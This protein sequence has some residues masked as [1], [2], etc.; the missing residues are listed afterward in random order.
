MKYNFNPYQIFSKAVRRGIRFAALHLL[1][2]V[3]MML[4]MVHPT[5]AGQDKEAAKIDPAIFKNITWR[6]IGPA[7]MG[8]RLTDI[9]AVVGNPDIIYFGTASSGLWKSTNG[10]IT[11]KQVFGDQPVHSIGDLAIALSNP[12]VIYVGTGEDN[13]RNSVSYGNGVYKST[14]AGETW[15]H[16]GLEDTRHIS[17]VIV[18][19]TNADIAYV[20]ALG[21]VW[22]RNKERGVF[23]TIDGGKS[24]KQVLFVDEETGASDIDMDPS[25]PNILYAAMWTFQRNPWTHT[26]GSEKG[27]IYK[28][29]D[30]GLTW[31]KVEKGLPKLIGRIG[32][33]VAPSNPNVVYAIMEAK[34]GTLYRSDDRGETWKKITD[35]WNIISRGFYY[36]E[37]RVDPKNENRL[38]AVSGSLQLS[39][40][41]GR[42]WGR[43]ATSVHGD[44]HTLWIDPH[45]PHLLFNGNDG[46][47]GISRDGGETWENL[48]T[49]PTGQFYQITADNQVPFYKVF[50]G[51]Q[52]NGSWGGPAR[53]RDVNGILNDDWFTIGGGDGFFVVVHPEKQHLVLCE[54]Q[55]GYI[56]R[57]DIRTGHTQSISPQ[58]APMSG[59]AAGENEYRFDWNAPIVL[60]PHDAD[61]VYLGGNVLFKSTDFGK[62]WEAISPDLSTNDPKKLE[63]AGGPIQHE[64]TVAEYHCVIISI[65]ESPVQVGVIWIGTDDGQIQLTEDGGKNWTNLTKNVKG[66]P[67]DGFIS[68]VEASKTAAGAAYMTADRHMLDD[69][70]PYVFKTTDFGKTWENISGNLPSPAYVHV[71]REDPLNPNVLYVG[72]EIGIFVSFTGGKEWHPFKLKNLPTTAVHDIYVHPK[73]NDLIIGTHGYSI[74]ILDDITFLQ[75]LSSEVMNSD[76]YLFEPQKAWRYPLWRKK[77]SLGDKQFKGANPEY[78]ALITYYLK[79]APDD[80][81]SVKVQILDSQEKLI[82]EIKGTRDLG[83]NRIVWDLRHEAAKQRSPEEARRERRFRPTGPQVIPGEYTAK[84]IVG[85]KTQSKR[86]QVTLDPALEVTEAEIKAQFDASMQLRD[87][88]SSLNIALHALDGIELQIKNLNKTIKQEGSTIPQD[89][90]DSLKEMTNNV[91]DLQKMMFREREASIYLAPRL[92]DKV[93]SLY[94]TIERGNAAPT[95]HQMD[96]LKKLQGELKEAVQKVNALISQ[97]IPKLNEVLQNNNLPIF[98]APKTIESP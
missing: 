58:P 43:I 96:Y 7:I 69:L 32:V 64:N 22:G 30:G 35:D 50:G 17:R 47:I 61:T 57:V 6:S 31:K 62:Q 55:G 48:N 67:P 92:L 29:I 65:S 59:A 28:S 68:H 33:K 19:P 9:E 72:T 78:G 89:V 23:M 15:Q 34:E 87:M 18:H 37:L 70:N 49:L 97:D 27:G 82:R 8:G 52:D 94:G 95:Q 90:H 84:L 20:A 80:K 11:C 44:H 81:T 76:T 91:S 93:S 83:I 42:S 10:A 85:D 2:V 3:S 12:G 46:A 66:L 75:Q 25:N 74:W 41:G 13:P 5:S 60:S 38:Y 51:L 56:Q 24:W 71:I 54:S 63:S 86:L 88:V 21:H 14:D 45:N 1:I 77:G 53:S 26:S 4:L 40:D 36:T 16:V 79:T 39:T 98:L 73:A